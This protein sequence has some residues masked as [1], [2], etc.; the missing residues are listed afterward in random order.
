[1]IQCV[2]VP[3][4]NGRYLRL[5]KIEFISAEDGVELKPVVENLDLR[6]PWQILE[7]CWPYHL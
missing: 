2:C 4:R 3:L 7:A 5:A 1:M 6:V